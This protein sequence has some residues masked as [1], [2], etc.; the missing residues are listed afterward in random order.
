LVTKKDVIRLLNCKDTKAKT[1]LKEL[2]KSELE[3]ITKGKYTYYV[4]NTN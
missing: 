4:L 1:L 2:T 3:I